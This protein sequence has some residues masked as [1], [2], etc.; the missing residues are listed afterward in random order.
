[1]TRI[2]WLMPDK[3]DNIST[4]R[5]R[6][7]DGLESRGHEVTRRTNRVRH[8]ITQLTDWHDVII[9]SSAAGGFAAPPA[10]LQ[11]IPFVM[12]H[13]DPI[14]QMYRTSDYR[15][16]KMVEVLQDV[17]F[18]LADGILYVYDEERER[19]DGRNARVTR[20]TL[21]V[22]YDRFS[23]PAIPD[24]GVNEVVSSSLE[25]GFCVYIGGLEPIY[26]VE[27]MVNAAITHDIPL[28]VAG[29]GSKQHIVAGAARCHEK[30]HYLGI[31][32]HEHIPVL[33]SQAGA[34]VC[35]VDDPHTVKT[36]EYAAAGL[37]I[38]QISGRA[39][40]H[41][42]DSGVYYPRQDVDVVGMAMEW[43]MDDDATPDLRRYA[44]TH[45]Y[46]QVID[47]YDRMIKAVV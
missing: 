44:H 22:D 15:T 23:N 7:A 8:G 17:A 11:R 30:I 32:E 41:L 21:G 34:G 4:G 1:M 36:L 28:V 45:D 35:L 13:V 14:S 9:A 25:P 20:T 18:R 46:K 5:N 12:D 37:P 42:P 26:N 2:L 39:K 47:D 3:P 40:A 16:A 10:K 31:V 29:V 43:A 19:V 38:V 27:L 6:I 33:L 24:G